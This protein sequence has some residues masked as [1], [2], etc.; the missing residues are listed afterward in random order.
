[1]CKRSL[2]FF[3]MAHN[4]YR[5]LK[6][7][8]Q[9]Y[10]KLSTSNKLVIKTGEQNPMIYTRMGNLQYSAE[11]VNNFT[12]GPITKKGVL[13]VTTLF[14]WKFCF[15]LRTLIKSWIDISTTQMSIF[16]FFVSAGVVFDGTFPLWVS[17][18]TKN[19]NPEA[20]RCHTI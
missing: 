6:N 15:S 19:L 7:S 10:C 2:I 18:K 9:L 14:F 1:M 11:W 5:Y 16:V 12:G 13:A 4:Y 17:L 8:W 3:I 20:W